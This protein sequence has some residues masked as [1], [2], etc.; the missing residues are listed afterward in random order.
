MSAAAVVGLTIRGTPAL[1]ACSPQVPTVRSAGAVAVLVAAA[2]IA[3]L[4]IGIGTVLLWDRD[5]AAWLGGD[6]GRLGLG[7]APLHP[8]VAGGSARP[9]S[10]VAHPPALPGGN[11]ALG[12]AD[13]RLT[14]GRSR[15]LASVVARTGGRGP[16]R[17]VRTAVVLAAPYGSVL[18]S[19][20]ATWLLF[21]NGCVS[22]QQLMTSLQVHGAMAGLV[23]FALLLWLAVE[24]L[25]VSDELGHF[26]LARFP[27]PRLVS[28]ARAVAI[29]DAALSS[30]M[31]PAELAGQ[32]GRVQNR[33][34]MPQARRVEPP[35]SMAGPSRRE[36]H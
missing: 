18:L 10:H 14:T 17:A 19:P 26:L 30:G 34:G 1:V 11:W 31:R 29:G 21:L 3:L 4:A 15:R 13:R 28:F 36:S 12:S 8:V 22:V 20:A 16:R 33:P 32:L 7:E 9:R 23:A 25:K 27:G 2:A 24:G 35:S 6:R 5:R